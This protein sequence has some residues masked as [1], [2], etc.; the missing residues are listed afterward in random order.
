[1]ATRSF[2]RPISIK[3]ETISRLPDVRELPADTELTI[4]LKF[5]QKRAREL[6]MYLLKEI[7]VDEPVELVAVTITGT[8]R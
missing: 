2:H 8:A 4:N 6:A 1:M 3:V 7:L 5:D